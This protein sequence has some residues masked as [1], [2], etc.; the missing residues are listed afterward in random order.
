MWFEIW[1]GV[2]DALP[3]QVMFGGEMVVIGLTGGA[4]ETT[5][6]VAGVATLSDFGRPIAA[7]AVETVQVETGE[8]RCGTGSRFVEF[9][10]QDRAIG[11]CYPAGSVV[12]DT[13]DA[14]GPFVVSPQGVALGNELPDSVVLVYPDEQVGKFLGSASGAVE[15]AGRMT[16]CTM[17]FLAGSVLGE[18]QSLVELSRSTPT[19]TPTLAPGEEAK[20]LVIRFTGIYQ[21]DALAVAISYVMDEQVYGHCGERGHRLDHGGQGTPLSKSRYSRTCRP[22]G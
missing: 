21:G 17:R 12:D 10:D 8:A 20:P 3:R 7:A 4:A 1:T 19:P 18:G 15:M 16:M 2:D 11:F 14:C 13:V 9:A 6:Q 5:W 22:W